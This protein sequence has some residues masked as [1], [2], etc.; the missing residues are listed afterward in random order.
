MRNTSVTIR[1]AACIGL[2]IASTIASIL[3]SASAATADGP[4][5]R[6]TYGSSK[7]VERATHSSVVRV[8][9]RDRLPQTRTV[10]I[11]TNKSMLVELPLE[12][13]DV[14][15][16]DPTIVDAVVQ[17]ST[18]VYLIA[19]KIG[20][21]N[22]FFFDQ[23]GRQILILEISVGVDTGPLDRVLKRLLPG[24]N[25]KS[26]MLN[27]TVIL[28]GS[29]RNA[30]DANTA[31]DI[32]AR[33]AVT[34]D[35]KQ[36]K[37]SRRKVINLLAVEGREQVM[38]RVKIVEVQRSILKQ[39][40]INLGAT[41]NSGNLLTSLLTEN[42]LPLTA[43]QGLGTLPVP[44]IE[45]GLVS[46]YNNGPNNANGDPTFGTSGLTGA[47]TSG[48]DRVGYTIRA[49]E[50]NGVVKT[51]AEPNMTAVSGETANFL[52][53]G[54]YPVPII[55]SDGRLNVTFKE[56]GVGLAFT[57]TVMSEGRISLKIDSE[58]SELSN[59]GAVTLS[60]IQIP[61]LTKRSAKTT[62]ELPSGGSFAIA[63]LIS[64]DMRRNVDG[65]PGL[66]DLPVLGTLFRSNDFIKSE[67][68]LVVIVTPYMVRPT[69]KRKL[70]APG[71]G[72]LPATDRRGN[73]MGHL[74][75]IYGR[76]DALPDGGLKGDY[77]FIVE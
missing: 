11:G 12:L 65:F 40:G 68:E 53:G 18:R 59:D 20:Q 22:A 58:V 75:R 7:I 64:E 44:G 29:V 33:F 76:G 48:A 24:S 46:L 56:F 14:L 19:K 66:K 41:I 6:R 38:L 52:A 23:S 51:L 34:D 21:A 8:T 4:T 15:V 37:E 60:N 1:Y 35:P 54:E 3:V 61:A 70:A 26:E 73:F 55:D 43:A 63:G 28:S 50:R 49:L 27:D 5:L 16:S 45:N 31:A 39:F 71:Q 36:N 13:R 32:A 10:T 25:I 77:G 17:S 57:P 2:V 47:Y 9:H 67:S 72:L 62:V 74:N 42:A 69:A 30:S